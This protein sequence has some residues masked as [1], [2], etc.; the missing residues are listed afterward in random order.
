MSE[1]KK[2]PLLSFLSDLPL[3]D[4]RLAV[5]R[6]LL[7][8]EA[9]SVQQLDLCTSIP[10]G[11]TT[12]AALHLWSAVEFF[13]PGSIHLVTVD[14]QP[15][16][17]ERLLAVKAG[18]QYFFGP[19]NGVLWPA[20]ERFSR[21]E[22]VLLDQEEF[23]REPVSPAF[24]ERDIL[25]SA[26]LHLLSGTAFEELG[27]SETSLETLE[28]WDAKGS[29]KSMNARILYED[30]DGNLVTNLTRAAL[31]MQF[32]LED[33]EL[34]VGPYRIKGIQEEVNELDQGEVIA[35]FNAFGLVEIRLIGGKANAALQGLSDRTV[36]VDFA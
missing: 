19:D 23:H 35:L 17:Q 24:Q 32:A 4:P 6:A 36:L 30:G 18:G 26:I 3:T 2:A 1:Q 8:T 12:Q 20:I 31:R 33:A 14:L 10:R 27:S 22:V 21:Y 7:H 25:L 29:A 28:L 13:P 34:Y 11:D 5:L 15:T 9:N 16:R